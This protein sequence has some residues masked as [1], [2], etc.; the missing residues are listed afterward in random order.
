MTTTLKLC[1]CKNCPPIRIERGLQPF[2]Q[3][4]TSTAPRH[5]FRNQIQARKFAEANG[6]GSIL[7][8]GFGYG[9]EVVLR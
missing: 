9:Y 6:G 4:A 1:I 7:A 2:C 5:L 3:I 8:R